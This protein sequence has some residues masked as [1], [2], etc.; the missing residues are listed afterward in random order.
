MN[1]RETQ[2]SKF[3]KSAIVY[4]SFNYLMPQYSRE[5]HSRGLVIEETMA[6]EDVL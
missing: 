6:F 5:H 3:M 2:K 1:P 4:N